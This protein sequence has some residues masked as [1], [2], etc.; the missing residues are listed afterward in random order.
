[1][2]LDAE[3]WKRIWEVVGRQ[4]LKCKMKNVKRP[5]LVSVTC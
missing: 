3:L 1:M 5:G 2:D 4:N